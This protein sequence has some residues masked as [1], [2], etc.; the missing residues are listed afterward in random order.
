[1]KLNRY[2]YLILLE[3]RNIQGTS[4]RLSKKPLGIKYLFCWNKKSEINS[5]MI[6]DMDNSIYMNNIKSI[7]RFK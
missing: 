1:M 5:Q 7:V 4:I 6:R 2:E 3:R